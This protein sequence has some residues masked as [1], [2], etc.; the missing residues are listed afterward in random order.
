[1][2]KNS[3]FSFSI[4]IFV[5]LSLIIFERYIANS[6][7][8]SLSLLVELPSCF[9]IVLCPNIMSAG[10]LSLGGFLKQLQQLVGWICLNI[11]VFPVLFL[12]KSSR[13]LSDLIVRF[14][15][16][17]NAGHLL[18]C[19]S[20]RNFLFPA[21]LSFIENEYSILISRC[22]YVEVIFQTVYC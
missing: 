11:F 16:I 15:L 17:F 7:L 8:F 19:H 4:I 22:L 10:I 20:L 21:D 14:S 12:S 6:V 1:M 3:L 13:F 18:V 9:L 2:A 5:R